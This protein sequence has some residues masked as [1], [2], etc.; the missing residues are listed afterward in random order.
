M[1]NEKM[2]TQMRHGI[3]EVIVGKPYISH[4]KGSRGAY[5]TQSITII[6]TDGAT[7]EIN[8]FFEEE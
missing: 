3:K 4:P 8:L 1:E 5:K 2:N 7:E 6:S